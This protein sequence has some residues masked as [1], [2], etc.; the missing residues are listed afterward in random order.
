MKVVRHVITALCYIPTTFIEICAPLP[1]SLLMYSHIHTSYFNA[2]D[3]VYLN[4]YNCRIV[5][6]LLGSNLLY[7]QDFHSILNF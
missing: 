1:Y 7:D 2:H 3:Y 4:T 6:I 5:Y